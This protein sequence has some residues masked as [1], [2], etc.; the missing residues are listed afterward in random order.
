MSVPAVVLNPDYK[1]LAPFQ[2]PWLPTGPYASPTSTARLRAHG[3]S[4]LQ[5]HVPHEEFNLSSACPFVLLLLLPEVV[6]EIC[7]ARCICHCV[8]EDTDP[9]ED[10][11]C[12]SIGYKWKHQFVGNRITAAEICV[13]NEI[14][15]CMSRWRWENRFEF[16]WIR[17]HPR[18]NMTERLRKKDSTHKSGLFQTQNCLACRQWNRN[19]AHYNQ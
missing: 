3:R 19:F 13:P 2:C 18:Q 4:H 14:K 6:A 17:R 12:R 16:A 10:V 7:S 15:I 8:N 1:F 11:P 5:Y 9:A